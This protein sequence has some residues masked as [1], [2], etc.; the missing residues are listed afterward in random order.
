M[1]KK[2]RINLDEFAPFG[3]KDC[4]NKCEREVVM[5]RAGVVIIC[6]ACKRIVMDN[7]NK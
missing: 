4:Q 5:S 3:T 2:E 1:D 6:K 7:R